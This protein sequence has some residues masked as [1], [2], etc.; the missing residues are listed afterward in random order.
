MMSK[1]SENYSVK[2]SVDLLGTWRFKLQY[3]ANQE[4]RMKFR[5]QEEN[6]VV[7]SSIYISVLTCIEV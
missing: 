4:E 6:G 1:L 5:K 3:M 2:V 7:L